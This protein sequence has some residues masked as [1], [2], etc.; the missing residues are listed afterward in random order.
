MEEK[1]G[2]LSY[3][4]HGRGLEPLSWVTI[5]FD[6]DSVNE[7]LCEDGRNCGKKLRAK[8]LKSREGRRQIDLIVKIFGEKRIEYE[9][10]FS[11]TA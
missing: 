9:K 3:C 5:V 10:R 1:Y 4:Y 11:N 7:I 8:L 6:G 2:C